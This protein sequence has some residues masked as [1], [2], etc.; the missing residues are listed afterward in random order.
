MD[1]VIEIQDYREK[2]LEAERDIAIGWIKPLSIPLNYEPDY[3][4]VEEVDE[5][6]EPIGMPIV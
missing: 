1:E 6:I 5:N 2:W 4:P 3:E